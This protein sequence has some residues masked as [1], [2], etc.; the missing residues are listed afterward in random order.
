M[1]A[2]GGNVGG[3]LGPALPTTEG[4]DDW[5]MGTSDF[6]VPHRL[7]VG[8]TARVD[9][10]LVSGLYRF[11]SG[12]PF[13][14]RYRMGV[15]ANGDG[16]HRNDVAF[17]P[18]DLSALSEGWS[19][20]SDQGGAFAS[21]NSCRGPSSHTVNIRVRYN[22]AQLVG[23]PASITVDGLNLIE[24]SG[25]II[26]DALLL[27]DPDGTITTSP[28]GGTVTIPTLVNANFGEVLYPT[29]RGRML[30]VGVR[31]GG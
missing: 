31:I 12:T 30:R 8:V 2:R 26:D 17:V 28:D 11:R 16:S 10:L 21:R 6:D 25:G 29:S 15:D 23:Q 1:G 18:T 20:L 9:N 14:P 24:T 4:A 13:T 3:E 22:F 7:V 27:V 19:C 5:S